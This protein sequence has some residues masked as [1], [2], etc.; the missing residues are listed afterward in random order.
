MRRCR[1][2]NDMMPCG[3]TEDPCNDMSVAETEI[4]IFAEGLADADPTDRD[5]WINLILNRV[6]ARRRAGDRMDLLYG[7]TPAEGAA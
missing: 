7:S 1:V 2:I 5:I 4:I 3:E 6:A